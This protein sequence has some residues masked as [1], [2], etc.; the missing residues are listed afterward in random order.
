MKNICL[1]ATKSFELVDKLKLL[2]EEFIQL[3]EEEKEQIDENSRE[4]PSKLAKLKQEKKKEIEKLCIELKSSVEFINNKKSLNLIRTKLK[5][6]KTEQQ[7]SKCIF[8][9]N[10]LENLLQNRDLFWENDHSTAQYTNP[11]KISSVDSK[12]VKH[13]LYSK[14]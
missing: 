7:T 13:I 2:R 3:K 1:N 8:Y 9:H 4:E 14:Y 5:K 12:I 6:R 10:E 11:D